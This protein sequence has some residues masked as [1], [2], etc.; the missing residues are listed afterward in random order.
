MDMSYIRLISRGSFCANNWLSGVHVSDN[1]SES[2]NRVFEVIRVYTKNEVDPDLK[3]DKDCSEEMWCELIGKDGVKSERTY[4]NVV[5]NVFSALRSDNKSK[6][7]MSWPGYTPVENASVSLIVNGIKSVL[8]PCCTKHKINEREDELSETLLETHD[9]DLECES[10]TIWMDRLPNLDLEFF[11][12]YEGVLD[13][14]NP[15]D[16]VE[17]ERIMS[18]DSLDDDISQSR[19]PLISTMKP[20]LSNACWRTLNSAEVQN[21]FGILTH[22]ESSWNAFPTAQIVD[23]FAEF[24]SQGAEYEGKSINVPHRTEM[25]FTYINLLTNSFYDEKRRVGAT[26]SS[27]LED[28]LS[29]PAR[30]TNHDDERASVLHQT[31]QYLQFC[32]KTLRFVAQSLSGELKDTIRDIGQPTSPSMC[33]GKPFLSQFLMIDLNNSLKMAVRSTIGVLMRYGHWTN[34]R[35]VKTADEQLCAKESQS[36][37]N[38]LGTIVCHIAFLFCL[39]EE[40]SFANNRCC[41]IIEDAACYAINNFGLS[42]KRTN[43]RKTTWN[44]EKGKFKK[45]LMLRFILSLD[46]SYSRALQLELSQL[47]DVSDDIALVLG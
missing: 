29:L 23:L 35:A 32:S 17:T 28:F 39:K 41:R 7:M 21:G 19:R 40:I 30:A 9:E 45:D 20:V 24:L 22:L 6:I 36:C 42:S 38:A 12:P 10:S 18:E 31:A 8:T 44:D 37:V 34:E 2:S 3:P 5:K 46:T 16:K 47:F 25:V 43:R 11:Y 4:K 14:R 13:E 15:N 27:N 26:I 1:D 33:Y